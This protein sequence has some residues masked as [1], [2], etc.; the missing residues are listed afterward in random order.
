MFEN[1]AFIAGFLANNIKKCRVLVVGDVMLD[2]YYYGEVKRI[3]PEA[4]VPVTRVIHE[5]ETLGGAANVVH[6]LA[7]LG[8]QVSLAGVTG[9]DDNRRRL[10]KLLAGVGV[11]DGGLICGARP[12]TAKLRVIGGHQQML[13]LDFEDTR[14]IAPT[15]A[16]LLRRYIQQTVEAGVDCIVISDYAKG[17]CTPSLCQYLIR[18]GNEAGVPVV[19][20]PKGANWTKYSEAFLI[21][22]N[23][24]ELGEAIHKPVANSDKAVKLAAD[25]V[26]RR[27]RLNGLMV[28]RSEKGLSLIDE[29]MEIHIPARA[30]EVFDVSGAG[31][32]VIAV[33]SAALAGRMNLSDAAQL[34]NLA[35]GVVVAKLGTY[36]ISREE[37]TA[38]IAN[39]SM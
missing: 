1:T 18:T 3:S 26:R 24:K 21:T 20:D 4:P 16:K 14:P 17:L 11:D 23:L 33:M 9:D 19:V 35:A 39:Y 36:A 22:P 38:A 8:C 5:K 12:T 15:T 25:K 2:R 31:D 10:T 29:R 28:T 37:L 30:Q 7:L 32:T 27:L 6:N 13:R 34:A